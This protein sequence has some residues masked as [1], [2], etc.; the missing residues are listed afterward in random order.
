MRSTIVIRWTSKLRSA[1][2][3]GAEGSSLGT[4]EK[5]R[6]E[7]FTLRLVSRKTR[8]H[9]DYTMHQEA[10]AEDW[11]RSGNSGCRRMRFAAEMQSR[12]V[13]YFSA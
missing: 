9:V 2:L 7:G 5:S 12:D 6:R 1:Q 10:G 11:S 8:R 4:M 13:M 3:D